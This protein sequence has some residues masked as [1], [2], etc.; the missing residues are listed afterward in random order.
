[1][2]RYATAAVAGSV[3][4]RRTK[5]AGRDMPPRCSTVVYTKLRMQLMLYGFS[6]GTKPE[7]GHARLIPRVPSGKVQVSDGAD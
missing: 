4:S 5:R 3:N 2:Q 7:C 6:D 1:M